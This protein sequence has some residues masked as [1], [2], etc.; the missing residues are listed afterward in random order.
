MTDDGAS[1]LT[2]RPLDIDELIAYRKGAIVSST[3]L[4]KEAGTV[5]L[6]SFD[7][8]QALSEHTAPYDALLLILDGEAKVI[9]ADISHVVKAGEFII[10]PANEPHAVQ[11][12][13]QFKMLLVM[14]RS[15]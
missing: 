3:I 9:I 8:G 15:G 12:I 5:T 4:T 11:A 6:F 7:A 14:V 13:K 1:D 10:A 2:A